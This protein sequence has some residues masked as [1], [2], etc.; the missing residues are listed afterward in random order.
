M[1]ISVG[2]LRLIVCGQV[3]EEEQPRCD[4][5]PALFYRRMIV[6]GDA[7]T[8]T[9]TTSPTPRVIKHVILPP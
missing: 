8:R 2:N 9:T 4:H 7:T 6:A 1:A 5:I 3:T